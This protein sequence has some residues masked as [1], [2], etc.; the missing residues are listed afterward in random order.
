MKQRAV[1]AGVIADHRVS[2]RLGAA[3]PGFFR[4]L[5]HPTTILAVAVTAV[6]SL[7]LWAQAERPVAVPDYTG[8]IGG[9]A[10]SPF[11]RGETPET[12]TLP[13]TEEIRADLERATELTGRVRTYTVQGTLG[14]I[15][16][17]A[18]DLPLRVTLGAWI[19]S[20]TDADATEVSRLIGIARANTN[21]DR[22]LIGNEVVLRGDLPV[23]TLI[24][25]IDEARHALHVPV[26]TAEPW[27]VWLA[28]PELAKSVDYITI[29]L[30]PYWEGLPVDDALRFTMEKY[31][32]VQAAYP[33][34]HIVIGEVG[35]PSNG[36]DIG[37]ARASRVNQ[38]M[39]L[40][41]F[42]VEA[43]AR[44]LDYFVMEAFD[45]PWKTSFEGRAAGYWGMMDLDRNAK[46]AMTGPVTEVPNWPVWAVLSILTAA[47]VSALLL[48]RR[49]DIRI[50][51]K[52]V[53][54]VLVQTFAATLACTLLAMSGKYLS[55]FATVIWG[56]LAAGQLL[57]LVLLVADSFELA[58][59]VWGR[60]WRRRPV[61]AAAPAN[62]KL[63]KVSI[64]IPICNE[65][66]HMVRQTLD[67]L[68]ELDYAD[69]EV[70]VID[71]NTVDPALW[72]P[73]AEHCARLGPKFR[74]F[75]LGKW[76]GFK[77]GALNFALRETAAD[78]EIV[79]VLDSDYI[80]SRDWLRCMVPHFARP[81][82]GFVQ[83][84]QDYRD[85]DGSFFKRLMFW[86]YAG[87]FQLGMVT[88]NE[89]NAIIQHG[90]MTLVRKQA[91]LNADAHDGK[92]WAE[93]C[94]CE[95]AEL[96]LKLFRDGWEA[97]Y[98][99][100]SFGRGVMPDDF[101]AFRK[102]RS[103]WAYGAMQICRRHIGALLSPFNREL[104]LGQKW[105]F[106]TGW[107]PWVGDA[108]GLLFLV[109][110]LIWSIGLIAAPMRF[111]FPIVLFM[112]PSI[113]LF[114]FKIAQIFTLYGARVRCGVMDR[115]GA[116]IAGLAL[117][118]T[119][120]K[121]VWKGLFFKRAPFLRTPKMKDAPA[122][123]Q[124][125][126]MAREELALLT[127]TWAALVGVGIAHHFSTW[128]A[129]LWCVVL[130]TQSLPYAASV[131]V[132]VFAALPAPQR[133]ALP[134]PAH[135][136]SGAGT[137]LARTSTRH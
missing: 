128:E 19:D 8:T 130:F 115:V 83:S 81:E 2:E 26:S 37:G 91:L 61:V 118:H 117:S 42:F 54:T 67:A 106:V 33:N 112:V 48:S 3:R 45:Q 92:S 113:G 58:E 56:S 78:A 94:I 50:T 39:F 68:A 62:A 80:V 27:H 85:N 36:V 132:S 5:L 84:P 71:N 122:L 120:G 52:L 110:G 16:R 133:A 31:D 57:L 89:R 22:V 90:T 11:H 12:N 108:L 96:G 121:A 125:L 25:Y 53:L 14:A 69:Y 17:L 4:A 114:V 66:P 7:G 1:S 86:E 131:L 104:T 18:N 49:P 76:Q 64:H 77:A 95:D 100:Q 40:R 97:V 107:L 43:K 73:V 93:W 29:H 70:L 88:R 135:T 127:L 46:W 34:K 134:M 23:T 41:K 9:V 59:T 123:V 65:P 109:M 72:E 15:P 101:A 98:A 79:G 124:G 119:I 102:Q 38:A 51:G 10:F 74:F 55:T 116:A 87:F 136:Q 111:E 63:P 32:A 75:H 44:H 20:H 137:A 60:T 103:R 30:L 35:W 24:R 126:V 105:H 13:T 21:V 47:M 82:V 6:A 28:H 129:C 99:S